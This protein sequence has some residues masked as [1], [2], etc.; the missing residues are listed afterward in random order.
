MGHGKNSL[1][2]LRSLLL[3]I[4][5]FQDKDHFLKMSLLNNWAESEARG[6]MLREILGNLVVFLAA[7]SIASSIYSYVSRDP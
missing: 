5:F 1:S 4:R 3:R 7:L 6:W 2:I